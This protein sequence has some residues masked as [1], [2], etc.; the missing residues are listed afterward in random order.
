[1]H[2]AVAETAVWSLSHPS[3]PL[4]PLPPVPAT[5]VDPVSTVRQ[6][7]YQA[8]FVSSKH[9]VVSGRDGGFN[10]QSERGIVCWGKKPSEWPG[11][12]DATF[13]WV[14]LVM[15]NSNQHPQSLSVIGPCGFTSRQEQ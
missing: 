1:M 13:A 12:S 7:E 8:F 14:L 6:R 5:V 10:H 9:A 15:T 4:P 11:H 2:R 3:H